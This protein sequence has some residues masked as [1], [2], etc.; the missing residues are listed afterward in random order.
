MLYDQFNRRIN[1]L[2]ISVTD[3]CNLRC[4]YCMPAE[5]IETIAHKDILTFEEIVEFTKAAVSAGINKVRLTGG[6]PLVRKGIV[7]L[8]EMLSKIKGINDLAMTTNGVLLGKYANDL[9]TAG[10]HRVN[11]SLDT[12][13]PIKFKALTR[14]GNLPDV[15]RGIRAAQDA[16]L[17]PVKVNCV[18]KETPNEPDARE[19]LEWGLENEVD[20]RFI[21]QMDMEKGEFGI[22]HGGTGGDCA[23]CNRL[24]LTSNGLLKPCLFSDLAI[25]IREENYKSA[26]EKAIKIKPSCGMH[27]TQNK[28]YN[29]GG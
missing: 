9:K 8:V 18:I 22:V 19:L 11:V 29:I 13:H 21:K 20:V 7:E 17:N 24:R 23:I 4:Q 27:N 14:G 1:Y 26:I 16:G 12:I 15:L 28:F 6:E 2:R 25:N 5:G 10:L 3:R